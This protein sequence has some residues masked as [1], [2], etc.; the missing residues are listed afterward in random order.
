MRIGATLFVLVLVGLV[1]SSLIAE[2]QVDPRLAS[3]SV[4]AGATQPVTTVHTTPLSL[5]QLTVNANDIFRCKVEGLDQRIYRPAGK[6]SDVALDTL[7]V[8]CRI[9]FVIKGDN[10]V[11]ERAK[12]VQSAR[13]GAHYDEGDDVFL[14]LP[15]PSRLNLVAPLGIHSG[16]FKIENE[17]AVNLWGNLGLLSDERSKALYEAKE[18]K[19]NAEDPGPL[20][21]EFLMAATNELLAEQRN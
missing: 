11:G 20:S 16:H 3:R 5:E 18:P 14:Y 12:I 2:Q 9:T 19:G 13:F 17:E 21:V 15:S 1:C 4:T 7:A 6:D 10:K 8:F